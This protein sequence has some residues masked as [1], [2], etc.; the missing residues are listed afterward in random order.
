MLLYT[1]FIALVSAGDAASNRL[2]IRSQ[3][4]K[5]PLKPLGFISVSL[6]ATKLLFTFVFIFTFKRFFHQ[7]KQEESDK[8]GHEIMLP[9]SS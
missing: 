3:R 8:A 4:E 6:F 9:L 5:R 2:L 7:N 1:H